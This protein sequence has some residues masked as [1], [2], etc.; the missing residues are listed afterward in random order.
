MDFFVKPDKGDF[1]GRDA[2]LT[3]SEQGPKLKLITLELDTDIDC[4]HDE[5]IAHQGE[6]VGWVTSGA[7]GHHV[8]KSLALGYVPAAL[9][10][11]T[12]FEVEILGENKTARRLEQAPYDPTGARM[13]S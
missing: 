7:Y 2:F 11:E 8:E 10:K 1:I 13:R 9:A 4:H 6:V 3:Q 5:P 12:E